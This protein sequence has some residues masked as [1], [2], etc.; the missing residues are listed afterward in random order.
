[1]SVLLELSRGLPIRQLEVGEVLITEGEQSSAMYVV[2]EGSFVVSIGESAIAKVAEPGAVLG[3]ISLLL[4]L[5]HGAT[6]TADTSSVVHVIDDPQS[7]MT[8]DGGG[9]LEITRLLARRLSRLNGYL[10]DVKAQYGDS[11][12]HL[13]LVDE[14]IS[15]LAFGEQAKVEPGSERDPDPY[16]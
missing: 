2:A 8:A 11:D 15:Q 1:M 13:G 12:G 3:E 4:D 10:V 14:I 16:Y 5:P 6:V 9:L 7:F